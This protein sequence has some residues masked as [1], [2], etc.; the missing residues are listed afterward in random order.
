MIRKFFS[1]LLSQIPD[2]RKF[3]KN[4]SETVSYGDRSLLL[5]HLE[6]IICFRRS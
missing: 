2:N 6:K 5:N 4:S 1:E 3:I